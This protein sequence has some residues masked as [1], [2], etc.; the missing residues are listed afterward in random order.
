MRI[1]KSVLR[2]SQ[3]RQEDD[4][5]LQAPGVLHELIAVDARQHHVQKHQVELLGVHQVGGLLPVR[6]PDAGISRPAQVHFYQVGDGLLR[7]EPGAARHLPDGPGKHGEQGER[8]ED[9]SRRLP[10]QAL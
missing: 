8:A 9:G 10:D 6:R 2:A 1:Q 4:G 5:Q 7:Q 3:G